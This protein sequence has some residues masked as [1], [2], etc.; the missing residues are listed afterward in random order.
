MG[1]R[2][3]LVLAMAVFFITA[4]S[5]AALATHV[6]GSLTGSTDGA[7]FGSGS[8]AWYH[9]GQSCGGSCVG[10]W[11]RQGNIVDSS[12]ADHDTVY[13]E[14]RVEAY[15]WARVYGTECG[16]RFVSHNYWDPQSREVSHA[17]WHVCRAWEGFFDNCSSTRNFDR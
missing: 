7:R 2:K 15:G 16:T 8:W 5:T 12:C 13:D 9:N 6:G 4:A 14:A 17:E 10:G 11:H 3:A 1:P